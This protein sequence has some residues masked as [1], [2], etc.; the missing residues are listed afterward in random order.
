MGYV[1]KLN[2]RSGALLWKT[3]VGEHNGHDND[4]VL[5]LSHKL[6]VQVPY[7]APRRDHGL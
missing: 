2:A 5:A 6:Q 3:P 1:Y 4:S 7:R